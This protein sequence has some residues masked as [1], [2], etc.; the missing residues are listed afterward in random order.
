M[1]RRTNCVSKGI[2]RLYPFPVNHELQ[3]HDDNVNMD[4]LKQ[5]LTEIE[6]LKRKNEALQ[7][8]VESAIQRQPHA[9]VTNEPPKLSSY[10]SV[11]GETKRYRSLNDMDRCQSCGGRIFEAGDCYC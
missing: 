6:E 10:G 4:Q 5:L 1:D 3:R 2:D 9:Q 8:Q 7:K 11:Y